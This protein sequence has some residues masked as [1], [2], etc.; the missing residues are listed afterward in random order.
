MSGIFADSR[1]GYPN[2]AECYPG[3]LNLCLDQLPSAPDT[4]IDAPVRPDLGGLVLHDVGGTLA[5]GPVEATHPAPGDPRYEFRGPSAQFVVAPGEP[6]F[7]AFA[8]GSWG[9]TSLEA[10]V[11]APVPLVSFQPNGPIRLVE[12]TLDLTWQPANSGILTLTVWAGGSSGDLPGAR[13]VHRLYLLEDDGFFSLDVADLGLGDAN[14]VVELALARTEYAD[15]TVNGNPVFLSARSERRIFATRPPIDGRTRVFPADAC[16]TVPLLAGDS[17]VWGILDAHTDALALPGTG[18]TGTPTLG[19]DGFFGVVVEPGERITVSGDLEG[20]DLALYLLANCGDPSSC[21]AGSD[22]GYGETLQYTNASSA[23]VE[24][25]LGI[26]TSIPLAPAPLFLLDVERDTPPPNSGA[27]DDCIDSAAFIVHSGPQ[28]LDLA[29]ATDDTASSC[30]GVGPDVFLP[31]HLPPGSRLY[32]R[33]SAP[34]TMG[35]APA[36]GSG[37]CT[38]SAGPYEALLVD[39]PSAQALDGHLV[40][41]DAGPAPFQGPFD[42]DLEILEPRAISPATGCTAAGPEV[43]RTG[44][45]LLVG[46]LTGYP[47]AL[48]VLCSPSQSASG[49]EGLLEVLLQAGET[50]DVELTQQSADGLVYLSRGCPDPASNRPLVCGDTN[51]SGQ[52]DATRYS[53]LTGAPE[54]L[55]LVLETQQTVSTAPGGAFR[56]FVDIR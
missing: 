1:L 54:R 20:S 31:V 28:T 2:L 14:R 9:E 24:L 29:A 34:V 41:E 13:V 46:D 15:A 44:R 39:N 40:I 26:D 56:L 43:L 51:A 55:F 21:V 45:H 38:A 12:D 49:E 4:W 7:L 53:N 33:A 16:G 27:P 10:F 52:P 36:C 47:D 17:H 30:A 22:Y 23:P 8:G 37:G 18:C 42:V 6:L 25:T 11:A 3:A 32:A 48:D 19:P 5:L 50:I 35:L